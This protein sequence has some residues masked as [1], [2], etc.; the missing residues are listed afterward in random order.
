MGSAAA[1]TA[2]REQSASQGSR[3]IAPQRRERNSIASRNMFASARTVSRSWATSLRT[4]CRMSAWLWRSKKGTESAR[5]CRMRR[6]SIP[7]S[8]TLP[9]LELGDGVRVVAQ[10]RRDLA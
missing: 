5:R 1:G 8:T 6:A 10:A 9:I 3:E 4:A 7:S 2:A